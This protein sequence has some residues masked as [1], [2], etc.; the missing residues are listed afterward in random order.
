MEDRRIAIVGNGISGLGALWALRN[1]PHEVHQYEAADRLSGH[2]NTV[3][4]RHNGHST[5]VDTGFIVLDAAMYSNFIAFLKEL[6]VKIMPSKMTFG[7]S[8][9]RGAFE[10]TGTSLSAL[11]ALCGNL[12]RPSFWS[13][14]F[15]IVRFNQFALDLLSAEEKGSTGVQKEQSIGDYLEKE[16]YSANFR[17]DY[18]IS[19]IACV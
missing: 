14:I 13:M 11:F 19:M 18:I 12:F 10:W 5:Q 16:G 7:V 6:N 1:S 17:D 4:S 3:A 8:R 15:G 9:D 2:T